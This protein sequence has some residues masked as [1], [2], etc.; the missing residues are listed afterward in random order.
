MA[1]KIKGRTIDSFVDTSLAPSIKLSKYTVDG[2]GP[3]AFYQKTEPWQEVWVEDLKKYYYQDGIDYSTITYRDSL[4]SFITKIHEA[5]ID[6]SEQTFYISAKSDGTIRISHSHTRRATSTTITTTS[7]DRIILLLQAAGGS[8]G[9]TSNVYAAF[10]CIGGEDGGSGGSGGL[11]AVVLN[12]KYL[13][14][15]GGEYEIK[16]GGP[17]KTPG[18]GNAPNDGMNVYLGNGVAHGYD[19][20]SGTDST[21]TYIKDSKSTYLFTV[22]AGKG[23]TSGKEYTPGKPGAGGIVTESSSKNRGIFYWLLPVYDINS[24]HINDGMLN[25]LTGGSDESSGPYTNSIFLRATSMPGF[26]LN[27]NWVYPIGGYSGG[28]SQGSAS[29]GGAASYFGNGGNGGPTASSGEPGGIGAG[30]G[31][32]QWSYGGVAIGLKFSAVAL[33]SIKGGGNGGAAKLLLYY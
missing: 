25:G 19:G 33:A 17:G 31:G 20:T 18:A 24:R 23:G 11:L 22:G 30:G 12:T 10:V 32:G 29:A 4:G 15:N 21:V 3:L 16:V 8:G 27:R 14:D 7:A 26:M 5:T 2:M 6:D 13:K 28:S 1:Y 9:G